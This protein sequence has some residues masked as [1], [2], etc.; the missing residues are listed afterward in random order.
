MVTRDSLIAFQIE[1][2]TIA[3]QRGDDDAAL[4]WARRVAETKNN[5]YDPPLIK[6]DDDA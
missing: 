3:H 2:F 6:E 5:V 4:H 1:R